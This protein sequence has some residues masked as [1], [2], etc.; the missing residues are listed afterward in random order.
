MGGCGSKNLA[1]D[2]E[3][4]SSPTVENG[5]NDGSPKITPGQVKPANLGS[6]SFGK[7]AGSLA[8]TKKGSTNSLESARSE[9][10]SE[11]KQ[12]FESAERPASAGSS[13]GSKRSIKLNPNDAEETGGERTPSA[14]T[15]KNK[16]VWSKLRNAVKT[17][18]G[19]DEFFEYLK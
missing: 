18:N 9:R 13:K 2:P 19:C 12:T 14:S 3:S 8:N 5:R 4:I 7:A 11:S 15:P 1:Q 6:G 10:S 17:I 16:A